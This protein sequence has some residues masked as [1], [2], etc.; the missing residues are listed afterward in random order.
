[1]PH[2]FFDLP[3]PL[4]IGHRGCAG[5]RP[6]NTLVSFAKAC[7]DGAQILESDVHVTRDGV[8][9]LLH[10][11]DVSRVSDGT[12]Q[13]RDLS[14]AELQRLDAG[15]HFTAPDGTHPFRGQGV[16]VPALAEALAALPGMRFNLELKEDLPDLIEATVEVVRDADREALTLLTAA[17]DPLMARLRKHVESVGS[18]VALGACTGEVA[19]F[20]LAARDGTPPPD[21]PMALQIPTH[22]VGQPLVT[23]AL[24]DAAHAAGVQVHVWTINEPDEIAA[25]LALGVDGIVSD[26]PARVVA[27]RAGA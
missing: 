17:E 25:L 6:E 2:P 1:M 7:E 5:E 27:A 9:V 10:D 22:F 3:G 18:S 15:H 12:G 4:A 16:Q 21:G 11:D 14:L 24:L 19:G 13:V 26:H 23:P 20:A 8:P